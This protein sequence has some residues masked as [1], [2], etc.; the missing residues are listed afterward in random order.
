[1]IGGGQDL[2]IN[3]SSKKCSIHPC[4]REREREREKKKRDKITLVRTGVVFA[5]SLGGVGPEPGAPGLG[6]EPEGG[7]T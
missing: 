4:V 7:G 1:M 2:N 3:S 6:M 5:P